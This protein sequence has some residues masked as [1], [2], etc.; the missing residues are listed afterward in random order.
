[1]RNNIKIILL[2]IFF[3]NLYFDNINASEDFFFES[4]SI[5]I[6]NSS[7]TIEAKNGV[8][9]TS[10]DGIKI[11]AFMSKFNK[12]S[13]ILTL[14]KDVIINDDTNNLSIK[15]EKIIYDKNKEQIFSKN[16]TDIFLNNL[17][18]LEGEDIILDRAKL[19]LFSKKKAVIKDYDNNI[20]HLKDFNYSIQNKQLQTHQLTLIDNKG[21]RYVTKESIIDLNNPKIAS[22]DIELYFNDK[23]Q[24]GENARLKGSSLLSEN[25]KTIINN[26]IFTTCKKNEKCPPWSLKSKKVIHNIDKKII[27]YDKSTL[28]LYDVPIFYFPKFFHP[29]PSVKRQSGFLVPSLINSSKNGTSTRVP[30]YHV[31]DDHKD[32]TI[33]PQ[34]YFNKDFL[35]QNEFRQKEKNTSHITDFSLKK[36]E[37]SS[38]SHFFTNTKKVLNNGFE[39]SEI[40]INLEKTS[41]DT[42]LKKSN[43]KTKTRESSNQSLLNSYIKFNATGEDYKIFSEMSVFEDLSKSNNSDK[44]QYIF[45]NFTL[46]KLLKTQQDINGNLNFTTSGSVRKKDTNV[47]ERFLTN[48]L[49]YISNSYF[50]TFGTVSN[51]EIFLK[52]TIKNGKNSSDYDDDTQTKNY[53]LLS[54]NSSIPLKKINSTFISNLTPKILINFNPDKSEDISNLDRKINSTNLFSHN[55]LGLADSLEGGSS[56]T[57]GFDYELK[58]LERDKLLGLRLGQIFRDTG[59][60]RYPKK[61][62]MQNKSSDL[63]GALEINPSKNLEFNYEFSADNNL[64]TMNSSKLEGNIKINNFVTSFEFL[65]ENNDIGTDSYISNDVKYNFDKQNSLLFNTR[66]NRKTD[67]TEFYNLIYEYKNDCL[68]AAIEYNKDYYQDRDLKPSE[69]IFFKITIT[70]FASINSPS[71]NK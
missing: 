68:V 10:S 39:F 34:F 71:F 59:D 38:K 30:Y 4:K 41:N 45:P 69:E 56:A 66:R 54:L 3:F 7:N 50:S 29:D 19:I 32:L 48:D 65:E 13:K 2:T 58:N 22:K 46:S 49:N 43:I 18:V 16:K 35:V 67:L 24:L 37:R 5:E 25:K 12:T 21:N 31:I 33:T 40:E 63:I 52:N 14:E 42:Y 55:R 20:L 61:S 62:T 28:Q 6:L 11:N 60:D 1:M 53:S 8:V 47:E 64:D 51:L 70:P 23:G 9:I 57:F 27:T 44:Y 15:S 26:G 36:L 17:Y